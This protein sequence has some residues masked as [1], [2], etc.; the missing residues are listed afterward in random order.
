MHHWPALRN[1]VWPLIGQP[2][3]EHTAVSSKGP[4]SQGNGRCSHK[5][6]CAPAKAVRKPKIKRLKACMAERSELGK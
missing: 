2:R 4:K 6:S 1:S 3:A 5:A